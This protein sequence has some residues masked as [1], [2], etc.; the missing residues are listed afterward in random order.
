MDEAQHDDSTTGPQASPD[1]AAGGP[2]GDEALLAAHDPNELCHDVM[3]AMDAGAFVVDTSLRVLAANPM[4]QRWCEQWGWDADSVGKDLSVAFPSLPE[5][6]R[7]E[8]ETVVRTGRPMTT[9]RTITLA[10]TALTFE[11]SKTPILRDDRIVG[12]VMIIS[13]ITARRRAEQA[14]AYRLDLDTLIMKISSDF[15]ALPLDGIDDGIV[16]ALHTIGEFVEVDRSNV[17]VFSRGGTRLSLAMGW[18]ADGVVPIAD[19]VQDRPT[20]NMPWWMNMLRRDQV[21]HVPRV[22]ALPPEA[23]SARAALEVRGIK[24]VLAV[25][26]FHGEEILGFLGLDMVRQEKTWTQGEISLLRVVADIFASALHRKRT[27]AALRDSEARYR[28]LAENAVDVTWMTDIDR[29]F[30]YMSPSIEGLLGYTADEMMS[31]GA[32]DI[33]TPESLARTQQ[34][35]AEWLASPNDEMPLETG[36][37][38]HVRK[39]GALLWCEVRAALLRD[40]DGK[41]VGFQGVTRDISERRAAAEEKDRVLARLKEFESIVNRSPA[42]VFRW[43]AA[44]E[45]SWP[46][47]FVSDNVSQ[48]GYTPEDFTSGRVTWTGATH[49]D[50]VS[51]LDGEVAGYVERGIDTFS[52]EYRLIDKAGEVRW[53]ED[54]NLVIRN[55]EGAITHIQG[56][57]LDVTD[58]HM[59]QIN[60]RKSEEQMR[61]IFSSLHETAIAVY[62]RDGMILDVWICEG[63]AETLQVT[64]EQLIGRSLHDI[65]PPEIADKRI[66]R[67][68]EVL[69]T[70]QSAR[71]EYD[72]PLPDGT[73]RA[74][75]TM[76]PL[77]NAD[78]EAYAVVAF[79]R[80]VTERRRAEEALAQSEQRFRH[81]AESMSDWIWEVDANGVYTYVSEKVAGVLGYTS[82]EIIGKTPFEFMPPDEAQR[83]GGAF[84]EIVANAAPIRDMENWNLTKNG[85]RVCL[86][87]NGIPIIGPGG[88]L[89]GYRGVDRDITERKDAE[90]ALRASENRYR[91]LFEQSNDAIIIARTDGHILDA[92]AR[93]C[94]MYGYSSEQLTHLSSMDL[95]PPAERARY[96]QLF[97]AA[98]VEGAARFEGRCMR[99]DGTVFDVEIS[100]RIVDRDGGVMQGIA[101]DITERKRAE[102]ALQDAYKKLLNARE[103]E[104]RRLAREL[105]DTVSQDLVAMQV[106]IQN[107][108]AAGQDVLARDQ[109]HALLNATSKCTHLVRDV[110]NICQ[111]LY[112][113]TLETLGLAAALR[114]L[115]QYCGEQVEFNMTFSPGL[116]KQRFGDVREIALYRIAQQAVNNALQHAGAKSITPGLW[117]DA[118]EIMLEIIDDG[119]GFDPGQRAGYGLGLTTMNDRAKAAGGELSITSEPGQTCVE[120]RVPLGD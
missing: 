115:G 60:L 64:P 44:P 71:D 95:H 105:H 98:W 7:E 34:R 38:E 86:L 107:A 79:I 18:C 106:A 103:A 46:V 36:E 81:I 35:A 14:L 57:V 6:V 104:R 51:R 65:Y 10:G 61:A 19:G 26:M 22:D 116:D 63:L 24:S 91:K 108:A 15:I 48:F 90:E 110:R 8:L 1:R 5:G 77:R 120:V 39:D 49:P 4:L 21:I 23:Q 84:A 101:R 3:L 112:P 85:R 118:T 109:M 78:G 45:E 56:I 93:A 30:T 89:A 41:A 12:A 2:G 80:D 29:R 94:E 75:T 47:E 20:D 55:A 13:D 67:I 87:T 59:A 32:P 16:S 25:P 37:Y 54:R 74:E 73:F 9:E 50:D 92:N 33:L 52:Q 70:G 88:E 82:D 43:R 102:R 62:D 28:L 119:C 99:S 83:I 27:E 68:R 97:K 96:E 58:R 31:M 42:V 72:S 114:Q 111:G 69:D 66:S 11:A 76:S 17:F 100:A 40:S 53:V 113:A 117:G